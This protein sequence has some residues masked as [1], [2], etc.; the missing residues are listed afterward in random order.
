MV[1]EKLS[2]LSRNDS[3]IDDDQEFQYTLKDRHHHSSQ[4]QR[5][6]LNQRVLPDLITNRTF[7]EATSSDEVSFKRIVL[8]FSI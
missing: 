2:E 7:Q 4:E 8:S 1:V 3:D 5:F 6:N